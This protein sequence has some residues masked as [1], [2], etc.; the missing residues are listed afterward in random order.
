MR[1]VGCI[2]LILLCAF[3]LSLAQ[4][5]NPVEFLLLS[6]AKAGAPVEHAIEVAC[7]KRMKRTSIDLEGPKLFASSVG[8]K[9]RKPPEKLVVMQW[10]EIKNRQGQGKASQKALDLVSSSS[11][12]HTISA[13]PKYFVSP[14]QQLSEGE[15]APIPGGLDHYLAF[16]VLETQKGASTSAGKAVEIVS[17]SGKESRTTA[18]PVF[19]CLPASEWHHD[20]S[21]EVTHERAGFIVY[22]LDRQETQAQETVVSTLDQF[23]L[24]ELTISHSQWLMA[25]ATLLLGK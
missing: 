18:K 19:V 23:G 16:P 21:F 12:T 3:Q 20:E 22:A 2:S 15:P 11:Q 17:A 4:A 5:H 13:S 14:A 1:Y 25:R 24:N 9:G 8:C 6:E 10:Y 7:D